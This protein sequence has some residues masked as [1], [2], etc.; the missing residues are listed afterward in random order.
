MPTTVRVEDPVKRELD[1]LQAEVADET[2][3]RLT[4]SE[5]LAR[6]L[7][8]ARRND[9]AFFRE[10]AATWRPPTREQLDRLFRG[11]KD[12]GVRTDASRID[13]ELYG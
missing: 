3:E 9:G 1:A 12:W 4:H 11:V 6:L 2:G 5:L 7:R 8:F 13:E 10:A